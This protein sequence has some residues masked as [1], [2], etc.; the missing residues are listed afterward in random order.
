MSHKTKTMKAAKEKTTT[1]KKTEKIK[2]YLLV[3]KRGFEVSPPERHRVEE[4]FP[5]ELDARLPLLDAR[6]IIVTAAK[7][8]E[9]V[10]LL[11]F[12]CV[13]LISFYFLFLVT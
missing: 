6:R 11:L 10:L 4:F 5:F 8:G 2:I 13:C 9:E 3:V 12:I 7:K 1:E